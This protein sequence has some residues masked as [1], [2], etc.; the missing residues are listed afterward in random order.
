[1]IA[2]GSWETENFK[3]YNWNALGKEVINGNLHPLMKVFYTK[4]LIINCI[5]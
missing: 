5:G 3:P 2:D 4:I 1:M